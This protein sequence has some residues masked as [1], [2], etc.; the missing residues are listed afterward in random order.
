[1]E[2]CDEANGPELKEDENESKGGNIFDTSKDFTTED[3]SYEPVTMPCKKVKVIKKSQ[4]PDYI[5]SDQP[6]PIT[7]NH[8]QACNQSYMIYFRTLLN[9]M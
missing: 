8:V 7:M 1:M 4:I 6:S 2:E 9:S 3:E 5:E